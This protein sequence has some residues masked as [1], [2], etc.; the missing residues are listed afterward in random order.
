MNKMTG[1]SCG[2]CGYDLTGLDFQGRCPECGGIFD[3]WT[4]E[5]I[6]GGPMTKHQRGDWVV[7]L[8]QT[9]GLVVCALG[10]EALGGYYA[11]K[12]DGPG[13]LVLT[14]VVA[15]IFL[16]MAVNIGLSLRRL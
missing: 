14:T 4:G 10:V 9:I 13:P 12:T 15:L 6:G 2:R 3:N 16:A 1:K 11:Y 5:G 7:R 8:L